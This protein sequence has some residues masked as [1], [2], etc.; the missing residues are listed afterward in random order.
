MGGDEVIHAG[1]NPGEYGRALDYAAF[2]AFKAAS[3]FCN[4][5]RSTARWRWL[6]LAAITSRASAFKAA[7]AATCSC[8]ADLD[9]PI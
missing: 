3:V 4:A 9:D 8:H 2:R 1:P 7:W 5:R 6:R